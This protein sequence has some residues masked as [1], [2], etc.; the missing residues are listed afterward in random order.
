MSCDLLRLALS[1]RL[2]FCYC[3][4][5][6]CLSFFILLESVLIDVI[7]KILSIMWDEQL[8][9]DTSFGTKGKKADSSS[10][11]SSQT[12]MNVA[13]V[14]NLEEQSSVVGLHQIRWDHV[15]VKDLGSWLWV[16][17]IHY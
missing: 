15:R 12:L 17:H 8:G 7:S 16:C 6:L 10:V 4:P 5:L 2:S 9:T 3:V 14:K 1:R 13:M 11:C